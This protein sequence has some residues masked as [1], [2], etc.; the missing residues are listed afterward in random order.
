MTS[1]L[2]KSRIIER[3]V[4]FTGLA[5][6]VAAELASDA[7]DLS[8]RMLRRIIGIIQQNQTEGLLAFRAHVAGNRH[9][10]GTHVASKRQ[11]SPRA[12][13]GQ[14]HKKNL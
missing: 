13:V 14:A 10:K 6:S 11:P 1:E 5:P 2:K 12:R 9:V 3:A 8:I 7:K 4:T